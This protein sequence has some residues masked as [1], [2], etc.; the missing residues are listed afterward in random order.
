MGCR[1]CSRLLL[2]Y[3]AGLTELTNNLSRDQ[4]AVLVTKEEPSR[5]V[6]FRDLDWEDSWAFLRYR[7]RH[8]LYP[9]QRPRASWAQLLLALGNTNVKRLFVRLVDGD[10]IHSNMD[11]PFQRIKV[12]H[13]GQI[14]FILGFREVSLDVANRVFRAYSPIA[15]I[16]TEEVQVLG[17]VLRFEGDVLQLHALI[18]RCSFDWIMRAKPLIIGQLS[19]GMYGANGI[20]MPLTTLSNAISGGQTSSE[21][22]IAEREAIKADMRGFS[23]GPVVREALLLKEIFGDNAEVQA[24]MAAEHARGVS[25]QRLP[26][27]WRRM[28]RH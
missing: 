13:L 14:A 22:N 8:P 5:P 2:L 11:T 21:F 6:K 1:V 3:P 27:P 18:A 12:R 25:A 4:L 20:S 23:A 26:A 7:L 16:T 24:E 28:T 9:V 10:T 15:S 17:K 19:F